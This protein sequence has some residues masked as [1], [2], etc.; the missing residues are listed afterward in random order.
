MPPRNKMAPIRLY[1]LW[2]TTH[3]CDNRCTLTSTRSAST[4]SVASRC[5]LIS[6]GWPMKTAILTSVKWLPTSTNWTPANRTITRWARISSR[7]KPR[8]TR[9]PPQ[10][11]YWWRSTIWLNTS[12]GSR[13]YASLKLKT[14]KIVPYTKSHKVHCTVISK[15]DLHSQ[16]TIKCRSRSTLFSCK[17]NELM[18]RCLSCVRNSCKFSLNRN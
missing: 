4:T 10:S 18:Q 15:A 11:R 2:L 12:W 5:H 13:R 14:T 1:G 8:S 6:R 16:M 7:C 3:R 17:L 9:S